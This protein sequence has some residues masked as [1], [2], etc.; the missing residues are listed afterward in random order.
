MGSTQSSYWGDI[1]DLV[2]NLQ[3]AFHEG[4]RRLPLADQCCMLGLRQ[5]GKLSL[6]GWVAEECHRGPASRAGLFLQPFLLDFWVSGT[7]PASIRE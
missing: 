3:G 1:R 2:P 5:E 4:P 7:F 6:R